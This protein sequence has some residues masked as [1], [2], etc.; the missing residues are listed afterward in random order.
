MKKIGVLTFHDGI[1]HG[2]YMQAFSTYRFLLENGFDT[3]IIH[4]KNRTHFKNELKVFLLT[5]NP[6]RLI[7]NLRKIQAFKYDQKKMNLSKLK[8]NSSEIAN[9]YDTIIIGSDIVWNYKDRFLGND[10]IYFGEGLKPNRLI[11]YAPSFGDVD[12]TDVKPDFVVSGIK[13]FNII[14]VRDKNSA[15]IVESITGNRPQ[16]VLDPT[17]LIDSKPYEKIGKVSD[18]DYLLVYAYQL[19]PK[20]IES[21]IEFARTNSLRIISVGYPNRW[22]DENVVALGP[23]E[24]LSY[25]R[26]A[27]FVLTSTFH[28]TIFSIK[29]KRN[30]VTSMNSNN[31]NKTLSLIN[32][33]GLQKRFVENTS[34]SS[35]FSKEIDYKKINE[36][37]STLIQKSQQFLLNALNNQ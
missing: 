11:S 1:N 33:L 15:N 29:Y 17:F 31:K 22:A 20:E 27:K 24:W 37:L 34:L 28:G 19:R 7:Q 23:F 5:K 14:S 2:A 10:P 3:E 16:V 4:Y 18:T 25:F 8:M 32:K 9:E 6:I 36:N 35:I 21:A 13:K 26:N 30:F 12:L